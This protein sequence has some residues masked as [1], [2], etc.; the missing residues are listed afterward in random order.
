MYCTGQTDRQ[1]GQ[2]C[3]GHVDNLRMFVELA[4]SPTLPILHRPTWHLCSCSISAC[5]RH[6]HMSKLAAY[7]RAIPQIMPTTIAKCQPLQSCPPY[8]GQLLNTFTTSVLHQQQYNSGP[9]GP[10]YTT[11]HDQKLAES[12]FWTICWL[13]HGLTSVSSTELCVHKG[14]LAKICQ[15]VCGHP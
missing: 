10:W 12:S 1:S 14:V 3:S 4:L 5:A 9:C 13:M 15:H 2:D 6:E 8:N 7:K 11:M